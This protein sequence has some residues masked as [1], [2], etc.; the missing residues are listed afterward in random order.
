MR[1]ISCGYAPMGA[2]TTETAQAMIN[3][4][5][6]H[7]DTNYYSMITLHINDSEMFL[8]IKN[9]GPGKQCKTF[10]L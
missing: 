10:W 5:I 3:R 7:S 9:Y 8:G 6:M 4:I 1:E 2:M